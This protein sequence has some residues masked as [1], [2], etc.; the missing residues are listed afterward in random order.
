LGAN[1][2]DEAPHNDKPF[3]YNAKLQ[4]FYFEVEMDDYP[5]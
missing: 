2:E 5:E 4:K 1:A 3:D